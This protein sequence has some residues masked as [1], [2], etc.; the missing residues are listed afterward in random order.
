MDDITHNY[1]GTEVRL[2]KLG[3]RGRVRW[4]Q[5]EIFLFRF[6][7][8]C[9]THAC[10]CKDEGDKPLTDACC[11][12][13]C[14]VDLYEKDAILARKAEI[15][16][17]LKPEVQDPAK[18]FDES[19]PEHDLIAY[20]SGTCVRSAVVGTGCVFLQHDSRGCALHRAALEHN[21]PPPEIKPAV[22]RLY[23]L[24]YSDHT[25]WLSDDYYRYS[26]A[27]DPSGPTV[28]K[29]LRPSLVTLFGRSLVRRLDALE[30]SFLARRLPI[31]V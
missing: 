9:M 11:Q 1:D 21:F 3:A 23:P 14:D 18:W 28:Y 7:A 29:L 19:E 24:S 10:L 5:E 26:C 4:V 22:C 27:N 31:A 2:L 6:T 17:V 25:I 12:H 20:P 15:A 8:D 30:R 16:S 13:G